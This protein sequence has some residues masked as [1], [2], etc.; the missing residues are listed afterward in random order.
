MKPKFDEFEKYIGKLLS[1]E[2]SKKLSDLCE[3]IYGSE[4]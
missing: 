3:K 1:A 4:L 2:E